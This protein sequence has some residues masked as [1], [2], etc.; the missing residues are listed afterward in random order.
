MQPLS[1]VATLKRL[2]AA[3]LV[4]TV[5]LALTPAIVSADTAEYSEAD[6]ED[7][8]EEQISST[9]FVVTSA[10]Q[11][12]LDPTNH[13]MEIEGLEMEARGV[14]V[15]LSELRFTATGTNTS[16]SVQGELDFLDTHPRFECDLE[17][18]FTGPNGPL[19]VTSA[20][21]VSVANEP[22]NLS[23]EE[24]DAIA[25]AWNDFILKSDVEISAPDGAQL[26]T[27]DVVDEG[28]GARLKTTWSSEGPFYLDDQEIEDELSDMA[29]SLATRANNYLSDDTPDWD[30]VITTGSDSL[31]LGVQLS[32]FGVDITVS[33]LEIHFS[34][35]SASFADAVLSLG[36]TDISF[37]G[38]ADLMCRNGQPVITWTAVSL[39]DEY[40]GL[41]DGVANNESTILIVL[42]E[43]FDLLIESTGLECAFVSSEGFTT[44]TGGPLVVHE[45]AAQT[46]NI[47]LKAGWNMVSVPV[48]G[49]SMSV[50]MVFPDAEVVYT[51]DPATK[52]Y[53]MPDTIDPTRAY[54][55]ASLTDDT[56][57][58]T[59]T[60][61]TGWEV[62]VEQGWNMLGSIYPAVVDFNEPD[63]E[64][65]S[66]VE[67]FT[68]SWDPTAKSYT[69]KHSIDPTAGHWVAAVEDCS[70]IVE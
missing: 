55:V 61:V 22:I 17:F 62:Q 33:G 34:G 35:L 29:N 31:G 49:D 38:A 58:F 12:N 27:I 10:P 43:L 46:V 66:A 67:G 18:T 56:V 7:W 51:W 16:V 45:S 11:V 40:P 1:H 47:E 9:E 42:N 57:M 64:P 13:R 21:N 32:I 59:G 4:P 8:L 54:W 63:D 36:S 26:L 41:Q 69:F 24:L 53:Y 15:G 50:D 65:D 25:D 68:Y 23:P 30:I 52:S 3:V 48:V 28:E 19:E 14:S 70:L 20:S 6:I 2:G 37:S 44:T 60:P 5:L 39:G